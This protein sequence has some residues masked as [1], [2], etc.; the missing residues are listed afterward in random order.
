MSLSI[1]AGDDLKPC[2]QQFCVDGKCIGCGEC[3]SDFLPVSE[4][5]IKRLKQYVRKHNL[6]EHRHNFLLGTNDCTC[7]FRNEASR[8]CDV[9]EVRPLI[10][11]SFICSKTIEKAGRD[12]NQIS[13]GREERSMRFEIFGNDENLSLLSMC[14]ALLLTQTDSHYQ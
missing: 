8:K 11:R 4:K 3:C 13:L 1:N 9:Y 14:K 2:Y 12:R 7:P 6:T 5:E 10:C